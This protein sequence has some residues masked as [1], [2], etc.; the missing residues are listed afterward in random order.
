MSVTP[1]ADAAEEEEENH[2]RRAP[3]S[4]FYCCNARAAVLLTAARRAPWSAGSER[5][6]CWLRA[7]GLGQYVAAS[8]AAKYDFLPMVGDMLETDVREWAGVMAMTPGDRARLMV[9]WRKF[10]QPSSSSSSSFTTTDGAQLQESGR[11]AADADAATATAE[12]TERAAIAAAAADAAEEEEVYCR[13]CHIN[14]VSTVPRCTP[15]E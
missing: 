2:A 11:A 1:D 5:M 6:A 8:L 10:Q 9:G 14:V 3:W 7:H 12:A 4:A 13:E 15:C